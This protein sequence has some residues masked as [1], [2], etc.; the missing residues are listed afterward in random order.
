MNHTEVIPLYSVTDIELEDGKD[1]LKI[2]TK[3]KKFQFMY[4]RSSPQLNDSP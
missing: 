3:G 1:T 2:E 4:V